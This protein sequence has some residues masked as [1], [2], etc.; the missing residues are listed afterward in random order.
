MWEI[1]NF[2]RHFLLSR[3]SLTNALFLLVFLDRE[4]R[5]PIIP[6]IIAALLAFIVG[7]FGVPVATEQNTS[8]RWRAWS[9]RH[10]HARR[11]PS[12]GDESRRSFTPH[13][14]AAGLGAARPDPWG[15]QTSHTDSR[16]R[17]APARDAPD[18][19]PAPASPPY[20]VDRGLLAC[21]PY[22]RR[23]RRW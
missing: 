7:L 23:P 14:E 4:M 11:V 9:S 17:T 6:P 8:I 19:P 15:R 2:P 13:V 22:S 1:E 10:I 3:S 20:E 18:P 5:C 12:C 21:T 16:A